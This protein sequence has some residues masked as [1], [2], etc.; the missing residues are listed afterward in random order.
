MTDELARNIR[1]AFGPKS[2]IGK[3]PLEFIKDEWFSHFIVNVGVDPVEDEFSQEE[4]DGFLL[5]LFE[6]EGHLR[7]QERLSRLSP[8]E[9]QAA[10]RA[11]RKPI[12]K[13]I[14]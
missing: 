1:D 6:Q 2:N 9:R 11:G 13:H 5:T 4:V 7:D 8:T 14:P 3:L 10:A 12:F